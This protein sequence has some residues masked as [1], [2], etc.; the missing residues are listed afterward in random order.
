MNLP[1]LLKS[2]GQGRSLFVKVAVSIALLALL[3]AVVDVEEVLRILPAVNLYYILLALAIITADRLLMS[4]KWRILLQ[5]AGLRLPM[6]DVIRAYYIGNLAGSFL[7][8]TVGLDVTRAWILTRRGQDLAGVASSIV[9]E[10]TVGLIVLALFSTVGATVLVTELGVDFAVA[11]WVSASLLAAMAL[12]F[13]FSLSRRGRRLL[14]GGLRLVPHRRLLKGLRKMHSSYQDYRGAGGAL[15]AFFALTVLETVL[16]IISSYFTAQALGV[17]LAL[18]YFFVVMPV[19][20]FIARVPALPNVIGVQE[21]LLV[22]LFSFVD[23][24]PAEAFAIGLVRRVLAVV[25][26]SPGLIFYLFDGG[27]RKE[28]LGHTD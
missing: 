18:Y 1:S 20:L 17:E 6:F 28:A 21:G 11:A 24:L 23:V 4:I 14:E 26:V 8:T 3:L 22:L 7:P 19:Y 2:G 25:G 5:A 12:A 13:A 15:A 27:A 16:P 9:V 10:R